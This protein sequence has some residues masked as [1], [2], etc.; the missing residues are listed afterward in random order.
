MNN[1]KIELRNIKVFLGLSE[2]THCYTAVVWFRG[3]KAVEVSNRGYGGC[4]SQYA[5]N[6]GSLNDLE[7]WCNKNLPKWDTPKSYVDQGM[8]LKSHE[9]TLEHWC[10]EQVGKHL[11]MSEFKRAMKVRPVY[12]DNGKLMETKFK[13]KKKYTEDQKESVLRKH[14]TAIILNDMDTEEAFKLWEKYRS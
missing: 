13:G 6:G 5:L 8:P 7:L 1:G 2:E 10:A 4:D 14:P 3:E 11:E 12:V 9:T